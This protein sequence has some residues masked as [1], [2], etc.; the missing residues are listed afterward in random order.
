MQQVFAWLSLKYFFLGGGWIS[1]RSRLHEHT[2]NALAPCDVSVHFSVQGCFPPCPT[3]RFISEQHSSKQQFGLTFSPSGSLELP[4]SL[5]CMTVWGSWRR[6]SKDTKSPGL[7]FKQASLLL[8]CDSSSHCTAVSPP[9]T[10]FHTDS[11]SGE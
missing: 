3:W 11:C 4:L 2:A 10:I 1:P 7:G 9:Q 8:W 5:M 6:S